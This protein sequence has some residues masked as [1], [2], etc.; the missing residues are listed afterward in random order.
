MCFSCR[1]FS[2]RRGLSSIF[3]SCLSSLVF[4]LNGSVGPLRSHASKKRRRG[5]KEKVFKSLAASAVDSKSS[6]SSSGSPPLLKHSLSLALALARSSL[7]YDDK[8]IFGCRGALV[9]SSVCLGAALAFLLLLLLLR[10]ALEG[11][12]EKRR[13]EGM[14]KN[15]GLPP[16]SPPPS[17]ALAARLPT[18]PKGK[19]T[20]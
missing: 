12:P 3:F 16:S 11:D 8:W 17:A 2:S 18:L 5:K 19:K 6:S 1:R 13:T 4:L 7:A 14:D 15:H 9:S 10:F 20:E